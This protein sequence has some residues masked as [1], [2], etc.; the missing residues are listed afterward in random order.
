[1]KKTL[2]FLVLLCSLS[3]S[4]EEMK[5]YNES[6]RNW[7]SLKEDNGNSYKYT[8]SWGSWAGFGGKTT[9]TIQD[10]QVISRFYESFK[11][12]GAT[13]EL[14]IIETFEE[15]L[16]TLNSNNAGSPPL[17]I[18]ELYD[19]CLENYLKVNK[20]KN[21]IY[22]ET[23]DFGLISTCGFV[24]DNCVDDCFTGFRIDSFEWL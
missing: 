23:N 12:D 10:N 21:T 14:T 18:D 15:T 9:M 8:T 16:E 5:D 7:N 22:F 2:I 13:G 24:P 3:C 4:N 6:L 20:N 17:T 19:S 1:M 11:I